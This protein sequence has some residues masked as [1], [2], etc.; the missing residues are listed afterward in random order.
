MSE[1][2]SSENK[3]LKGIVVDPY[4]QELFCYNTQCD[5]PLRK[6]NLLNFLA[7]FWKEGL[8]G[9]FM[10][11]QN[12]RCCETISVSHPLLQYY[13]D[14]ARNI[15]FFQ[16]NDDD[17]KEKDRVK[18]LLNDIKK[19]EVYTE[20][21]GIK[22]EQFTK[23]LKSMQELLAKITTA[24]I[25]PIEIKI[26][27][28][29]SNNFLDELL[30]SSI[31]ISGSAS[32]ETLILSDI[33]STLKINI[34]HDEIATADIIV[35][36]G[37]PDEKYADDIDTTKNKQKKQ[38]LFIKT[39]T[40]N[41]EE[42]F[43]TVNK[44]PTFWYVQEDHLKKLIC[45]Y[46]DLY[47]LRWRFLDLWE[48]CL[49]NA[50]FSSIDDAQEFLSLGI[51]SSA[52][53]VEAPE[54][55]VILGKTGEIKYVYITPFGTQ[56]TNLQDESIPCPI[57]IDL[58]YTESNGTQT[59]NPQKI[60][61]PI[62]K[63]LSYTELKEEKKI[64]LTPQ[65]IKPY[66]IS[67]A[68]SAPEDVYLYEEGRLKTLVLFKIK[69]EDNGLAAGIRLELT[70][71]K[72]LQ[73]AT[74]GTYTSSSSGNV[75]VKDCNLSSEK[76]YEARCG[77]K[78]S[79]KIIPVWHENGEYNR[80]ED[81]VKYYIYN[82]K[83][84]KVFQKESIQGEYTPEEPGTLTIIAE[85]ETS[86]CECKKIINVLPDADEIEKTITNLVSGEKV[87]TQSQPISCFTGTQFG[88]ECHGIYS[89]DSR[90]KV[91]NNEY[92]CTLL[93]NGEKVWKNISNLSSFK[94]ETHGSYKL[95]IKLCDNDNVSDYINFEVRAD[96]SLTAQKWLMATCGIG[97]LTTLCWYGLNLV[98][99]ALYCLCPLYAIHI[100]GKKKE[101]YP[102]IREECLLGLPILSVLFIL[103]AL[104][105]ELF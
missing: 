32:A 72:Y 66:E 39:V 36:K 78:I 58:S 63:D 83:N 4:Q 30:S 27:C 22:Y 15:S 70:E 79:F 86:K 65:E 37:F 92:K 42:K 88:I 91:W 52:Y 35:L 56:T 7:D 16:S 73:E 43:V 100:G 50:T 21:I 11:N 26:Y 85:T 33:C 74:G 82:N 61:C 87:D 97:L 31:N 34:K 69:V 23:K 51:S 84:E 45:Y 8:G 40:N 44:Y 71:N 18:T 99:F 89:K 13:V 48:D 60:F 77:E 98:T 75:C 95:E 49:K 1:E 5:K 68:T 9:L 10:G 46:I 29:I 38:I 59:T 25:S 2:N 76:M 105:E 54:K 94:L 96:Q 93:R 47:Y 90:Q 53:I 55:T 20:E 67:R 101:L 3:T 14:A 24:S 19:C 103:K 102:T 81:P 57:K 12:L 64:T 17:D 41:D 80:L 6:K 104:Y 28:D 62:K